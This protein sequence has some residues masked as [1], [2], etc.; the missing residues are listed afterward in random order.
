MG[1]SRPKRAI[2]VTKDLN[3]QLKALAIGLEA[4]NYESDK[5]EVADV[6]GYGSSKRSRPSS[7]R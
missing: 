3:M 1:R 6:E 5:V 4:Q 7:C 2:L